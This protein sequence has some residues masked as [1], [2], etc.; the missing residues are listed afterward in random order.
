MML[1]VLVYLVSLMLLCEAAP[2]KENPDGHLKVVREFNNYKTDEYNWGY[3]LSDGREVRESAYVK[4]LENGT[5]VLVINGYFSYIGPDGVRYS[6]NYYA[7][8]TGYHPN[9]VVGETPPHPVVGIDPK[10]LI[11]LVG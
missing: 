5:E 8:E 1:S 11:S 2:A 9:V 6:V 7:D 4:K 10:V 3:E